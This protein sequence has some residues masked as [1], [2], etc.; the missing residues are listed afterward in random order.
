MVDSNNDVINR[1][2]FSHN[3]GEAIIVEGGERNQIKGNRLV[4]NRAAASPSDPAAKT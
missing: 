2:R 3:G 4:D 1:N